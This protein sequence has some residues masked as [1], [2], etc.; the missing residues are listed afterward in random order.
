MADVVCSCRQRANTEALGCSIRIPQLVVILHYHRRNLRSQ[1][2]RLSGRQSAL[3]AVRDSRGNDGTD[4]LQVRHD[5]RHGLDGL[6]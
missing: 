4:R 2:C 1:P 3:S 6:L 5:G